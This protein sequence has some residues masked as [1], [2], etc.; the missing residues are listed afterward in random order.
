MMSVLE[1][2]AGMALDAL[3][4]LVS[5]HNKL[6]WEKGTP[7]ISDAD[8]DKLFEELRRRDPNHPLGASSPS[9]RATAP[10]QLLLK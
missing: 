3:V 8:Y 6:Y 4:E 10:L 2:L 7:E 1:N 9:S 5:H